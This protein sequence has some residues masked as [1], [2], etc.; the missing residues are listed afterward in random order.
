MALLNK[1]FYKQSNVFTSSYQVVH[2]DLLLIGWS[3]NVP[4][5]QLAIL[6]QQT[7][8]IHSFIPFFIIYSVYYPL[9][10]TYFNK[11]Y[12]LKLFFKLIYLRNITF[13]FENLSNKIFKKRIT[14]IK[15]VHPRK[16]GLRQRQIIFCIQEQQ[17]Y[18]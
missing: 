16:L 11:Y 6:I 3:F 12:T 17:Y 15:V 9:I 4:Q 8:L 2:I 14:S 1:N 13:V 5:E 7:L 10:F 18:Y